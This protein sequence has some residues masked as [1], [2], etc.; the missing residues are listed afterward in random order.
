MG[1]PG[2]A[3]DDAVSFA[4]VRPGEDLLQLATSE[5]VEE[6]RVFR[7]PSALRGARGGAAS[8]EARWEM[9]R[10]AGIARVVVVAGRL[11]AQ[12]ARGDAAI[13][14]EPIVAIDARGERRA[15]RIAIEQ[16][17][18]VDVVTASV[19][20]AG[21]AFPIALDPAWTT[22]G[23]LVAARTGA[24]PHSSRAETCCTSAAPAGGSPRSSETRP[25]PGWHRPAPQRT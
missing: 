19:D 25:T 11:E 4:D 21:L 23:N 18:G 12:D 10:G 17:D 20:V 16:R 8:I 1:A 7:A 9:R 13:V 22:S 15:A 5:G 2:I 3:T 24:A 14:S 6:V